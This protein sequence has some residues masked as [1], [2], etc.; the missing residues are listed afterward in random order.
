MGVSI[1]ITGDRVKKM[2]LKEVHDAK[3]DRVLSNDNNRN[4]IVCEA[5]NCYEAATETIIVS[6]GKF[7]TI[8]FNLCR[9]CAVNKFGAK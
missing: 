1:L 9:E 3:I 7:G 2:V 4:S 5:V 6:A 8:T